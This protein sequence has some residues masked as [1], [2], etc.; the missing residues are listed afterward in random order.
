L[1]YLFKENNFDI[2]ENR[3]FDTNKNFISIIKKV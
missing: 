2:I 3:L 1:E